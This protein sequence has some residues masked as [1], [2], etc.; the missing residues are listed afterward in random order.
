MQAL[1]QMD[2]SKV[3]L[4]EAFESVSCDDEFTAETKQ[5]ALNLLNGVVE[6]KESID[7]LMSQY[8]KDWPI[9]RMSFVDK[10]IIRLAI[11]EL[12]NEKD[13]PKAVIANEAVELAKKYSSDDGTS[14]I[15]GILGS[16]IKGL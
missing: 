10:N 2:I 9:D 7:T 12:L 13:T 11:Y 5:F 14:F 1:Y 16:V 4:D 15:N 6:N 3:T 8:S